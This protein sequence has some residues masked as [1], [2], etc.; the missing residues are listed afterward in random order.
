MPT[1]KETH[2]PTRE[3]EREKSRRQS[4]F[5]YKHERISWLRL[6]HLKLRS[7]VLLTWTERDWSMTQIFALPV[8]RRPFCLSSYLSCPLSLSSACLYMVTMSHQR[9]WLAFLSNDSHAEV[10]STSNRT[11][12]EVP[13]NFLACVSSREAIRFQHRTARRQARCRFSSQRRLLILDD[14]SAL[15]KDSEVITHFCSSWMDLL[16][17]RVDLAYWRLSLNE[18]NAD[19]SSNCKLICEKWRSDK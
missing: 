19:R 17:W 18:T 2:C 6:L 11:C 9:P 1:E 7:I 8:S 4:V 13:L 10:A 16:R 14:R 3:R 12:W 15:A 5:V